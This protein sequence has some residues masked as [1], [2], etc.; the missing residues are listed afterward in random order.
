LIDDFK[1]PVKLDGYLS[2]P[3]GPHH[4]MEEKI[5]NLAYLAEDE[6]THIFHFPITCNELRT[7]NR[8]DEGEII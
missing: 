3:K 7:A 8:N 4:Q 1:L 5:S 6:W 2:K